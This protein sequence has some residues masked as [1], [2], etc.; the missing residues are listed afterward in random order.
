[1]TFG[2]KQRSYQ[3]C[4]LR[5]GIL[6]DKIFVLDTSAILARRI[7]L[8]SGDII[9]VPSV[10]NEIRLGRIARAMD[11]TG[12]N[13]RI[14]SPRQ[15]STKKVLD[16][17]RET[18]DIDELSRTDI[19]V[20]AAALETGG[21]MVTDDYAMQNVASRLG[22]EFIG[23]DLKSI[24]KEINWVYRCTGCGRKYSRRQDSCPVCGHAL[25]RTVR[26]YRK[27]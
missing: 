13:L 3:Y 21:I 26:T 20:L 18:G 9:T 1:M 25:K 10:L 12:E 11:F 17:A 7:N 24:G 19:D 16:A 4:G 6:P 14:V 27:T 22:M 15:E 23:A 2:E 5:A 8:S